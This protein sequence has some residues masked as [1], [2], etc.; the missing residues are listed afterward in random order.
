VGV[1]LAVALA[2]W[3]VLGWRARVVERA[4]LCQGGPRRFAGLWDADQKARVRDALIKTGKPYAADVWKNVEASLEGYAARWMKMHKDSC[5]ATRLR[6]EQTDQVMTLRMVCLDRKLQEMGALV[7]VLTNADEAMLVKAAPA[8]SSLSAL[9]ACADVPGLLAEVPLPRDPGLRE[10]MTAIRAEVARANALRLAGRMTSAIEVAA[11]AV[12]EARA[13]ELHAVLAEALLSEGWAQIQGDPS[14]APENLTEAFLNAFASR[15]DHVAVSAAVLATRAYATLGRFDDSVQW[16]KNARAGLERVGG[17]EEQE[18]ELYTSLFFCAYEQ[19][20]GDDQ[21]VNTAK[22]AR[23]SER[24]FGFDD[25]RTLTK[26]QNELTALTNG[27][28]VLE[29]WRLRAPLLAR[30][31]KRLGP[32]SPMLAHW[33]MDLGDD[34]VRI[35]HLDDAHR[36]F[37]TAEKLFR[38]AGETETLSWAALRT[39]E[40]RLALA[41]GR[42]ADAGDIVRDTMA[43]L[44]R[45]KVL[46]S[47][48]TL[49]LRESQANLE[50][51]LGHADEALAIARRILQEAE[52]TNGKD[53]VELREMLSLLVDISLR[54]GAI[55]EARLL[56][57]RSLAL[58]RQHVDEHSFT[59]AVARLDQARVLLAQRRAGEALPL[60]D[61]SDPVLVRAVGEDAPIVIT[62]RRSRGEALLALERA[63]EAVATLEPTL[64]VSV[65]V[66]IDPALQ[67]ELRALVERARHNAVKLGVK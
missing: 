21:I 58:A 38:D 62:A 8:A 41:E 67:R 29:A 10:R 15:L 25:L 20:R 40:V 24:R 27:D 31:E 55:D 14:H 46:D 9:D 3:G 50:S 13:N 56:A 57:E 33:L 61:A 47:E 11:A 28:H 1:A 32:Q 63:N 66:G 54:A 6:G 59:L 18:A 5:E 51:R 39:Y 26:E 2:L 7:D 17:D 35:G 22:A 45:L 52:R 60:L 49:D 34:E 4:E 37:A 44:A 30:Q 23:L 12:R 53:D 64:A 42:L 16:E 43:L 65:R 19:H 36:H 48:R